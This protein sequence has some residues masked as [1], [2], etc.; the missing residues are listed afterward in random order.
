MIDHATART[1]FATS[2]D[3]DLEPAERAALDDHLDGCPACRADVAAMRADAAV[4]RDL[5]F[6]PVPAAVRA[7]IAIA[8]EGHG[9]GGPLG[10]WLAIG[11]VGALLLA[12]LGGGA[13]GVGGRPGST[14]GPDVTAA[15]A[16]P[17]QIAWKTDVVALTAREFSITAGGK[18]FRAATPKVQI[19]SDPGDATYRTLEATWEEN[20]VEM[21][22]NLY[23]GGDASSWWVDQVRIYNG[24]AEGG[25]LYAKGTFFKAALGD[26]WT[27]DLDVAVTDVDGIGG[28]PASIHLAGATLQN[29]PSTDANDPAGGGIKVPPIAPVIQPLGSGPFD[30]GGTLHCSGILQMTPGDAQATLDKMG[31]AVSWRYYTQN[32]SFIE[33]RTGPPS[34]TVIIADGPFIGSN[35]QLLIAIVD[36][37]SPLAKPVPFPA[38]CPRSDPNV[39]PP[40]PAP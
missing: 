39:T 35:G 8:A 1:S 28:T 38:D 9:R 20:G 40:P 10:R 30:P 23:F 14:A 32:D 3:F 13:L 2:L 19:H 7:N 36:P 16:A 11:A 17:N 31:I 33:S 29:D 26:A 6:G 15:A 22:L 25:W 21:R 27:G 37:T 12:A 18:T 34:G 24:A 4:L 5:D